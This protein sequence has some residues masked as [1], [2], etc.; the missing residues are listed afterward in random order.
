MNTVGGITMSDV[1]TY[2]I[3]KVIKTVV[4]AKR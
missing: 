3:A 4:L 2:Y 1:K